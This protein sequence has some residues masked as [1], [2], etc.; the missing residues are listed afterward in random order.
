MR[1]IMA[2]LLSLALAVP[3]FAG[4]EGPNG[5]VPA[6]SLAPASDHYESGAGTKCLDDTPCTLEGNILERLSKNKYV[7]QDDSGKITV[8]IGQRIFGSNR[9]TP[10]DAGEA[11]GR[12][13]SQEARARQ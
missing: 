2:L 6:D 12:S 9:V 1:Y 5:Q 7:F 3:A 13:G 11:D 8:E 10:G 4:F